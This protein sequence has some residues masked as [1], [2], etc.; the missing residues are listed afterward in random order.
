MRSKLIGRA[1]TPFAPASNDAVSQALSR[2]RRHALVTNDDARTSK[3]QSFGEMNIA[4]GN[5]SIITL[6]VKI[7]EENYQFEESCQ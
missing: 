4:N 3:E 7:K 2:V 5:S 6:Y 1:F